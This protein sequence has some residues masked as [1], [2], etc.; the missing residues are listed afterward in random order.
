MP[1]DIITTVYTY[2]ELSGEAQANARNWWTEIVENDDYAPPVIENALEVAKCLGI[3]IRD[4]GR[5]PACIYWSGFASQGDGA[6]FE[7]V[8][9]PTGEALA[10]VK[11]FAPLDETLHGIARD[12]D[13]AYSLAGEF[14]C[15][16]TTPRGS[17]CHSGTM[18]YEFDLDYDRSGT[19]EAD[20][21]V[22]QA[23]RRFADRIYS[24]LEESYFY[25]TSDEGV[26]ETLHANEYTFTAGGKRF[27]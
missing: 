11:E 27:G 14:R 23:L 22:R 18:D 5:G 25:V 16:V 17:Y 1:R 7:G 6:S 13:I 9:R 8:F 4:K 15:D 2:G 10:K 3:E 19:N 20:K 12:L 24:Q 21:L 26:A